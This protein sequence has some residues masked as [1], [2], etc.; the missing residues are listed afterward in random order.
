[1]LPASMTRA[2]QT[3]RIC[4]SRSGP[5]RRAGSARRCSHRPRPSLQPRKVGEGIIVG[6][7]NEMR[8][9]GMR[10]TAWARLATRMTDAFF[11][12]R[13]ALYTISLQALGAASPS[14]PN[15][16]SVGAGF[17]HGAI[18]CLSNHPISLVVVAQTLGLSRH[19]RH[20]GFPPPDRWRSTGV[21][22]LRTGQNVV[23]AI[24]VDVSGFF[25]IPA[26]LQRWLDHPRPAESPQ[27]FHPKW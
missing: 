5:S 22:C 16:R 13:L 27:W 3:L 6:R 1:M 11:V 15:G 18:H 21:F 2:A 7:L 20:I 9:V 17:S 26:T 12:R 14:D 23:Q 10:G 4:A 8:T 19:R 25:Y 24:T